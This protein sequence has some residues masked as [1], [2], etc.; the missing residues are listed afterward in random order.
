MDEF[1]ALRHHLRRHACD[2]SEVSTGSSEIF[3]VQERVARVNDER[4]CLLTV[5]AA[6]SR[7]PR[8][9]GEYNIDWNLHE[10]GGQPRHPV[11][12][13]IC[14]SLLDDEVLP[15]RVA[16]FSKVSPENFEMRAL[17]T[18]RT[19]LQPTSLYSSRQPFAR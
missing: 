18:G 9:H 15:L 17:G 2:T 1:E 3:Y 6:I 7:C 10:V 19:D 8:A 11:V 16:Q 13:A 5:W 4:C 12:L 14:K